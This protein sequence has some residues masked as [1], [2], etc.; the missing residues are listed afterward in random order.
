MKLTTG[1]ENVCLKDLGHNLG[2][3]ERAGWVSLAFRG[4]RETPILPCRG[5][6]CACAEAGRRNLPRQHVGVRAAPRAQR[7]GV[8][9]GSH[10]GHYGRPLR[11]AITRQ[12]KSSWGGKHSP[13][14]LSALGKREY[15]IREKTGGRRGTSE[16]GTEGKGQQWKARACRGPAAMRAAVWSRRVGAGVGAAAPAWR[17]YVLRPSARHCGC[18][19]STET[20]QP[21]KPVPS[22]IPTLHITRSTTDLPGRPRWTEARPWGLGAL[23]LGHWLPDY[24]GR[25]SAEGRPRDLR[26]NWHALMTGV[27]EHV[28]WS[29][30]VRMAPA[31]PA[32]S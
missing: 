28:G 7:G 2:T 13:P 24:W 16:G 18:A 1:K 23:V 30:Q 22:W 15:K 19:R 27:R 5:W 3:P 32:L 4:G 10:G 21:G 9:C 20:T 29:G 25:Q 31:N 17:Q 11:A 8:A 12:R 26:S 14:L 6:D